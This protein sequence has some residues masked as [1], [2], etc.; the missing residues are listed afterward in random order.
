MPRR[1]HPIEIIEKEWRTVSFN[2]RVGKVVLR[3]SNK[4]VKEKL[5][6][7]DWDIFLKTAEGTEPIGDIYGKPVTPMRFNEYYTINEKGEIKDRR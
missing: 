5:P 6:R 3:P 2:G 7:C 1:L 4:F